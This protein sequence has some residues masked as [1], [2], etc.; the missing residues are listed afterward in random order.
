VCL[1][2]RSILS[3]SSTDLS[4]ICC[5]S[6]RMRLHAQSNIGGQAV[7]RPTSGYNRCGSLSTAVRQAGDC[8]H[9]TCPTTKCASHP[10]CRPCEYQ[11]AHATDVQALLQRRRPAS[12]LTPFLS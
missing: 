4:R 3:S 11:Q 10:C 12:P 6:S 8:A 7:N 1:L 9:C 2:T 5:R